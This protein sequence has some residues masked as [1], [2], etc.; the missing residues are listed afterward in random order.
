MAMAAFC[1]F[2]NFTK[3]G[4]L[5]H[6]FT[7]YYFS[8]MIA[9]LRNT[10]FT[11]VYL[12]LIIDITSCMYNVPTLPPVYTECGIQFINETMV[13]VNETDED[14]QIS[15]CVGVSSGVQ[16]ESE[17]RFIVVAEEL[18]D[19]PVEQQ[20]LCTYCSYTCRYLL[21]VCESSIVCLHIDIVRNLRHDIQC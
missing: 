20:A 7:V 14:T 3:T 4:N 10:F 11:K 8:I 13:N 16:L 21:C 19:M 2:R 17:V 12:I 9:L 1:K 18:I 15:L 5:I 6:S